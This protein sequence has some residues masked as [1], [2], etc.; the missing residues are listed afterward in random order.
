MSEFRIGVVWFDDPNSLSLG[1][2]SLCGEAPRRIQQISDLES[3]GIFITNCTFPQ[4]ASV[5]ATK[6]PRLRASN[7]FREELAMICQDLNLHVSEAPETYIHILSE[8]FDRATQQ[9][10][11]LYGFDYPLSSLKESIYKQLFP[12]GESQT[13]GTPKIDEAFNESYLPLQRCYYA[14]NEGTRAVKI[15][16]S[17]NFFASMLTRFPIPVG[18]W[19]VYSGKLPSKMGKGKDSEVFKFLETMGNNKPAIC[20][21]SV[22]NIALNVGPLLGFTNGTI[23]RN[24]VPIHEAAFLASIADVTIIKIIEG[25]AYKPCSDTQIG[26]VDQGGVGD[27]SYSIGLVAE[28]HIAAISS[29]TRRRN[30]PPIYSPRASFLKAWDRIMLFKVAK[31]FHDNDITV[32]SYAMGAINVSVRDSQLD[33]VKRLALEQGLTPP[34]SIIA[35]TEIDQELSGEAT[36]KGGDLDGYL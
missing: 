8:F 33:T 30:Q 31:V 6:E 9:A 10:A 5:N 4:L 1:W 16:Y 19:S 3:D 14:G 2:A 22:K 20:Q 29:S 27:V 7:F 34:M 18:P 12:T 35:A 11:G 15:R 25:S 23:K 28:S 13:Y 26:W 17:R 24:W 32:S 36:I 21:I